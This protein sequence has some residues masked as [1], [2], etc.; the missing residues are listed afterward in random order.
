MFERSRTLNGPGGDT[1]ASIRAWMR[2]PGLR[3]LAALKALEERA[4]ATRRHE[5]SH[6][7]IEYGARAVAAGGQLIDRGALLAQIHPAAEHLTELVDRRPSIG[8]GGAARSRL[9]TGGIA[10]ARTRPRSSTA[11]SQRPGMAPSITVVSSRMSVSTWPPP[12]S[13]TRRGFFGRHPGS[14]AMKMIG[15]AASI[16]SITGRRTWSRNPFGWW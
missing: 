14:P 9:P 11:R 16:A 2:E 3:I 10:S 8:T 6:C 13:A 5:L 15:T 4:D 1:V 12:G 7:C